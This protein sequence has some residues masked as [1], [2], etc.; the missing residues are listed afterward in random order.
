MWFFIKQELQ[1]TAL[2]AKLLVIMM[3]F[4]TFVCP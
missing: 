1:F 2:Y 4:L 3:M